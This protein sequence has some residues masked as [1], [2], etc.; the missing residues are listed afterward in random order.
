MCD[1]VLLTLVRALAMLGALILAF[2]CLSFV[3]FAVLFLSLLFF[4]FLSTC[5]RHYAYI[6]QSTPWIRCTETKESG[7]SFQDSDQ[8]FLTLNS[9]TE[10]RYYVL[11]TSIIMYLYR[12]VTCFFSSHMLAPL[13]HLALAPL[14]LTRHGRQP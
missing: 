12:Y 8:I 7:H 1:F 14:S 3:S 5:V 4:L 11:G 9:W 2:Y 6:F 10:D 13:F